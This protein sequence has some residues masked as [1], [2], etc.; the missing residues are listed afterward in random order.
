MLDAHVDGGII[1]DIAGM[2]LG[3]ARKPIWRN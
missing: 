3:G 2:F 1:D